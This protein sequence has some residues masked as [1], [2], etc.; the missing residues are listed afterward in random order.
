MGRTT[1]HGVASPSG[2][3]G[4]AASL[5][6]TATASRLSGVDIAQLLV[7]LA[8]AFMVVLDFFIV[9]VALPSI[10]LDLAA[11]PGQLQLIV[12]GYGIANAAGLI[13]GGKLGDLFG[14]R[15]M[16][17]AGMALFGATSVAC[18]LATSGLVLV[19]AR[20]AQGA[21]GALLQPQVLALLGLNFPGDK[22]ARAFA[23]YAMA[24]GLAGVA[25]QLF[26]GALIEA[27]VGGLGWR[28]CFFVN[29]PVA[30][31]AIALGMKVLD[32][33]TPIAG[34]RA[35]DVWGMLLSAAALTCLI[36][37]LSYGREALSMSA[38]AALLLGAAALAIAFAWSQ[39]RR[40]ARGLAVMVP[41]S[42]VGTHGFGLGLVTVGVFYGGVASF[43]FVLGLHLQSTLGLSALQ[44]GGVFAILGAAFFVASMASAALARKLG[45]PPVEVGALMLVAGHGLQALLA[46]VGGGIVPLALALLIEG[47]GIGLVMAPL[48][49]LAL[50][51][52]PSQHAGIAAGIV[53]TIQGTGNALG[54]AVVGLAYLAGRWPP[55]GA[56]PARFAE[57][58]LLLVL[59]ALGVWRLARRLRAQGEPAS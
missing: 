40:A 5:P 39:R 12:A 49:S 30:L 33:E 14:R 11:T 13:A 44:S 26:G 21:T 54:V 20:F 1:T 58:L 55:A 15:R 16:F 8:G 18:G 9:L 51:R 38:N 25:G 31:G 36:V 3:S 19:L 32:R 47:A 57:A 53:S 23:A 6:Q 45:Q 17:F 27:D 28:S 50:S 52:L 7:I 43:Y 48:V 37:P 29:A 24:M 2:G 41:P 59:L 56:G 10:A 35:L 42:V 46:L 22:R 34:T 4:A